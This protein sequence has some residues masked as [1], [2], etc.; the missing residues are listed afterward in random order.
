M[1]TLLQV[2]CEECA[3][4]RILKVCQKLAKILTKVKRHVFWPTLYTWEYLEH[5]HLVGFAG[6]VCLVYVQQGD[7]V[8]F[9]RYKLSSDRH[10]LFPLEQIKETLTL[11]ANKYTAKVT[12]LATHKHQI[13]LD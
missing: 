5:I 1:I 7:V 10:C 4:E 3:S 12:K 6:R 2:V 9:C 11:S 13:N 8:T